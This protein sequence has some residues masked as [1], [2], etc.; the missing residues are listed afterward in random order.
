VQCEKISGKFLVPKVER[1]DRQQNIKQRWRAKPSNSEKI[2]EQK[3]VSNKTKNGQMPYLMGESIYR[4][5][6]W[7][8]G[9]AEI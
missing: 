6:N 2:F 4:I 5:G 3:I 9:L 8:S 1:Q 7:N